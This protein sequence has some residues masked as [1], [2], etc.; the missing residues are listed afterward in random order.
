MTTPAILPVI[1]AGGSGERLWPLSRS[2]HPKQFLNIL[3]A[4]I[5]L[6]QSTLQRT[7]NTE[8]FLPP[9]IIAHKDHR[10]LVAEQMRQLDC[11]T[12]AILLETEAKNTA[13]AVALAAHWATEQHGEVILLILPADHYLPD[14]ASFSDVIQKAAYI[15]NKYHKLVTCGIKATRAETGYGY[16]KPGAK[17]EQGFLV[18]KFI[19]KPESAVAFDLVQNNCLWNSG[20]FIF[21]N[22]DILIEFNKF[23]PEIA[24]HTQHALSDATKDFDFVRVDKNHYSNLPSISI[25]YAIMEHTDAAAVVPLDATWS[26]VG[27]WDAV[28]RHAK[29]DN[30]NNSVVGDVVVDGA[31]NCLIEARH[32][33]IAAGDIENLAIVETSDAVLVARRDNAQQLKRLVAELKKRENPVATLHRQVMRPWGYFDSLYK[34]G[35]CQVKILV[36][37]RGKSISLQLHHQRSEHWVVVKGLA[38]VTKGDENFIL[39]ENESTFIPIGMKHQL[40]NV[41]DIPLEV[42]EVQSGNYLGEDDIVRFEGEHAYA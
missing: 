4:K 21:L 35:R 41:G 31:K 22:S 42:V 2:A 9:L 15:A 33:L 24:E 16:I 28:W 14:F 36:L 30:D 32:R 29:K 6:F 5:S 11:H 1:L 27:C 18:D 38:R 8:L 40:T 23:C 17:L 7:A 37:Q 3:S 25:D 19:E 26:D 39:R 12:G 13:A 34:D 10:F 20:M